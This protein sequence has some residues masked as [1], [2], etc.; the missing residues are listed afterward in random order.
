MGGLFL[1]L[2]L[3]L[4]LA[5]GYSSLHAGLTG[6]PFSLG[7]A[8]GA[9]VGG[10]V[11]APKYGRRVLHGGVIAMAIGLGGAALSIEHWGPRLTTWDLAPSYAL[12]GLGFGFLIATYFGIVV[13]GIDDD[14]T[15]SAGGVM[16]ALQQLANTLGAALF[17]TLY[18]DGLTAGH[19]SVSAAG[20]TLGWAALV[21]ALCVPLGFLLPKQI[22]PAALEAH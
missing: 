4:Q 7:A 2:M 6:L 14:E 15:G 13:S 21:A 9:G 5:L 8:I 20:S 11:L 3:H 17:G 16:N 12:C 10:G 1:V 22:K 18:F 19:S